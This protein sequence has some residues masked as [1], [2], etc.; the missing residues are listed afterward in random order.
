ML[1]RLSASAHPTPTHYTLCGAYVRYDGQL[2]SGGARLMLRMVTRRVKKIIAWIAA[3]FVVVL[4]GSGAWWLAT[5][6]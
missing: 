2:D 1:Y 3:V 5:M 4:L 6:V